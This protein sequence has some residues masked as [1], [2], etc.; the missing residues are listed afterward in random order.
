MIY[1]RFNTTKNNISLLINIFTVPYPAKE[2]TACSACY[3][4][5][6]QAS[7]YLSCQF[8][9][10]QVDWKSHALTNTDGLTSGD[11]SVLLLV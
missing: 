9:G 8:S 1:I 7:A 2:Q 5:E 4:K 3:C 6:Y 10:Q 11:E